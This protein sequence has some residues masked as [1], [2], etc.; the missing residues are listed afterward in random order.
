MPKPKGFNLLVV[1]SGG[2]GVF[3]V[4]IPRWLFALTVGVLFFVVSAFV[5]ISGD[6]L[7][8]RHPRSRFAALQARVDAGELS[9][10]GG[11]PAGVPAPE[12][13][14]SKLNPYQVSSRELYRKGLAADLARRKKG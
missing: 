7:S 3:R 12:S 2:S 13:D 11:A 10:L 6:Y 4:C 9:T 5:A 1:K 14:A 8:L